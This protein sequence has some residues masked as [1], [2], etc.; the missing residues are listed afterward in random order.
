MQNVNNPPAVRDRQDNIR[1]L[2]RA[3]QKGASTKVAK[4]AAVARTT[5]KKVAKGLIKNVRTYSR[6]ESI[7][8][9][10]RNSMP[11]P[12][13]VRI[14]PVNFWMVVGGGVFSHTLTGSES[15]TCQ[16]YFSLRRRCRT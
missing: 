7:N 8:R 14:H 2:K 9:Q 3:K 13:F 15:M 1:G 4:G 6:G 10:L 5:N 11:T 12:Q 16:I